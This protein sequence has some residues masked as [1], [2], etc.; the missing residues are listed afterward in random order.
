MTGTAVDASIRL[1][2]EEMFDQVVR[3]RLEPAIVEAMKKLESQDALAVDRREIF[4]R[5][6][7]AAKIADCHPKTINRLVRNGQIKCYRVGEHIRI[8]R[9]DLIAYLARGDDRPSDEEIRRRARAA[10]AR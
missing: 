6:N 4:L 1:L 10:A 7:E 3:L 9:A 2:V 5:V 8:R